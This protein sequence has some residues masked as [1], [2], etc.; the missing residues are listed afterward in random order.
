M[1]HVIKCTESVIGVLI[2]DYRILWTDSKNKP[3]LDINRLNNYYVFDCDVEELNKW[4]NYLKNSFIK[5]ENNLPNL[6]IYLRFLGE[7]SFIL[8]KLSRTSVE[9]RS[10][11]FAPQPAFCCFQDFIPYTPKH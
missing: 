9:S 5:L 6:R 4:N 1:K 8:V 11:T 10:I 7:N 2:F 3:M